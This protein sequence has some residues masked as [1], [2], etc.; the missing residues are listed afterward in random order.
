MYKNLQLTWTQNF[1]RA[2]SEAY[3]I[4]GNVHV[5]H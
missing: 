5:M 4:S 1:K 3:Y 2:K